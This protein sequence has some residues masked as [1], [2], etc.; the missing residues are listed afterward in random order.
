MDESLCDLAA[1]VVA[2]TPSNAAQM[3]TRDR[4]ETIEA[5][6]TDV[7]RINNLFNT[8]V[9]ELI[10]SNRGEVVR[11][12]HDIVVRITTIESEILAQRKILEQLN[13][14]KVLERGYALVRGDIEVDNVVEITT[15]NQDIKAK[16]TEVKER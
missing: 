16:I 13:P 14:E 8:R 2:S 7:K 1:D 10:S 11:V 9:D 12:G 5:I 4:R 15:I 3:L 6:K